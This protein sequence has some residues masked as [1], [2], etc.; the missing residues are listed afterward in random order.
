VAKIWMKPT[1]EMS[2]RKLELATAF[3]AEGADRA[4][5]A[6]QIERARKLDALARVLIDARDSRRA[7]TRRSRTCSSAPT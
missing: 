5:R 7:L 6:E 3:V 4:C 2:L 1:D